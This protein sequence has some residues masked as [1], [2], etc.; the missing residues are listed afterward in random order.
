MR[1]RAAIGCWLGITP[2]GADCGP[3]WLQFS[4]TFSTDK[5]ASRKDASRGCSR[6][7]RRHTPPAPRHSAMLALGI[8]G[9]G[10]GGD[11]ARRPDGVGPQSW[12]AAVRRAK[13]FVWGLIAVDVPR[14][15]SWGCAGDDNGPDLRAIP[16]GTSRRSPRMIVV[17]LRDRRLPPSRTPCS[18]LAYARFGVVGYVFKKI[19]ASAGAVHAR[20]VL[21]SRA[22]DA[23][24]CR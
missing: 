21:G 7:R 22:E 1:A 9:S 19:S 18:T 15:M 23:F 14:Q 12:P 8:P 6:R 17:S 24:R 20:L 3:S 11:P 2:G 4:Q 5:T 16:A 10:H 13:D